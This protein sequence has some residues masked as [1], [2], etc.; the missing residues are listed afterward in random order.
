MPRLTHQTPKY[1]KHRASGQA[2]VELNGHRHYLG[3]HGTKA[4]KLEYDRLLG[5][6]LQNGRDPLHIGASEITVV[7]LSSRYLKFARKYYCKDGKPT[8]EA[9]N[10]AIVLRNLC[11]LYGRKQASEFGPR[12][13]RAHRERL[14]AEGLSRGYVN[15]QVAHIKRMFKWAVS[16]ELVPVTV[17]QTLSTVSGLRKG[18]SDAKETEPVLPVS[19]EII[20]ETVPLLPEIVADM[21]R[22]QRLTGCRPAE[23]CSIRPSDVD[24]SGDVWI[25]SPGSHKTEHHGKDRQIFIG[26][27]AQ[28]V[29]QRY[30]LRDTKQY[31]FR[32]CDSE[33][34]RLA[35]QH[36]ARK[37]P[38]SCGNRPK[39][40]A[41]KNRKRPPGQQ[42]STGSYCRAIHYA[43]RRA[44]IEKW[45]PN[46]LRHTAATEVRREFGLEGAQIILGHSQA[47]VTQVYAERDQTKGVDIARQIG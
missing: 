47:N 18:R 9:E 11:K 39:P 45:S 8:R 30:L 6:W 4:S 10:I 7:E 2:I 24:R 42:Y 21:V 12:A 14:V 20:S 34:D 28:E 13:L 23:V 16:E 15:K 38:M 1:R 32:P 29:L 37:T 27:R 35:T 26:P 40:F 25:Y 22:F 33:A 5:E 43:C 19:D 36:A 46:R 3:P 17:F 44:G 31:C 41:N